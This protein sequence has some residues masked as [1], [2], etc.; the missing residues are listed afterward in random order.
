MPQRDIEEIMIILRGFFNG[1]KFKIAQWLNCPNPLL[2]GV[3]PQDMIDMGR[4]VKLLK[5]MRDMIDGNL[6]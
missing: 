5:C 2:G 1:D 6:A 4:E 3:A